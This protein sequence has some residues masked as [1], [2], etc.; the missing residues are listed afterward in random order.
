MHASSL[1]DVRA[2]FNTRGSTVAATSILAYLSLWCATIGIVVLA[3]AIQPEPVAICRYGCLR[4]GCA[5]YGCA[6]RVRV[7]RSYPDTP[8]ADDAW[9][10]SRPMN[11]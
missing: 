9:Y 7:V 4:S 11:D 1:H 5:E 2:K 10:W 8:N 6:C 3:W